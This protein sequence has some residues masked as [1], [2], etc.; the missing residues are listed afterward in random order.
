MNLSKNNLKQEQQDNQ[1][2]HKGHK[3]TTF[4]PEVRLTTKVA[5]V[6]V[7]VPTKGKALSTLNLTERSLRS[8]SVFHYQIPTKERAIQTFGGSPEPWWLLEDT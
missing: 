3:D 8:N 6:S 5:Y 2:E 4:V 7:E 1:D